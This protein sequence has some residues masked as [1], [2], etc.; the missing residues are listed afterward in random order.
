[1]NSKAVAL[2][3][4]LG[5]TTTLAA[6]GGA[7]PG[8]G[9]E[10]GAAVPENPAPTAQGGEEGGAMTSDTAND[11]Q[12]EAADQQSSAQPAIAI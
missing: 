5:L 7:N 1:M 8:G 3:L 4:S 10:G 9:E 11:A 2:F 12:P 6:C